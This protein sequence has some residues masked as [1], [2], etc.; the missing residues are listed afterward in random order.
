MGNLLGNDRTTVGLSEVLS[1][2]PSDALM[3]E[4]LC[5]IAKM[6]RINVLTLRTI[7]T[8]V[9]NDAISIEFIQKSHALCPDFQDNW[10]RL[11]DY[12]VGQRF[13]DQLLFL[14]KESSM[15]GFNNKRPILEQFQILLEI[16][17]HFPNE[18]K[19]DILD[20][21]FQTFSCTISCLAM[22]RLMQ[23]FDSIDFKCCALH[24]FAGRIQ[25]VQNNFSIILTYL[26][27]WVPSAKQV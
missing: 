13:R 25:D 23:L 10:F 17:K 26:S 18:Q 7:L 20:H 21:F 5:D 22:V 1:F 4:V 16:T 11:L 8:T 3:V 27:I 2:V 19:L 6:T 15:N 12:F 14:A 24:L 9:N